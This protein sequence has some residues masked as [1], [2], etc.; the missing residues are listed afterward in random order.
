[1]GDAVADLKDRARASWAA[2]DYDVIGRLFS[3]VGATIVAAAEVKPG[4][5]VLDVG[6]GTGNASIPAACAGARVVASDLAPELFDAGRRRAAAAGVDIEWVA[7]DAEALPFED[8]SFDVVLSAFGVMFAPRHGVAAAELARVL[9]PG[10]TVALA[11]W[12]PNGFAGRMF[13]MV[14]SFLP[15]PPEFAS[16]PPLWGTAAHVESLFAGRGIELRFSR[17]TVTVEFPSPEAMIDEHLSNFGPFL[18]AREIIEP[19]GRWDELRAAF[20]E[21]VIEAND[22][23]GPVEIAAE[24]LLAAGHKRD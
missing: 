21:L 5:A 15:T 6:A 9:R 13:R 12:T 24:Y 16:P 10:G 7:A 17:E 18:A 8:E 19:E 20:R 11:N 22:G 2:G 14:A 23:S 1:M 4:E 3:H